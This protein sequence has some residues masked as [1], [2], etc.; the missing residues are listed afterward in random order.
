MSGRSAWSC[1]TY[2][3]LHAGAF[4]LGAL[5]YKPEPEIIPTLTETARGLPSLAKNIAEDE[6]PDLKDAALQGVG[7]IRDKEGAS[8]IIRNASIASPEW[9][10]FMII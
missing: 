10:S 9:Q 4:W 1:I 7:K 2:Q 5:E 3:W 6:E 8:I